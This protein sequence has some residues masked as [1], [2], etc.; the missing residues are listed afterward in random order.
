MEETILTVPQGGT[1]AGTFTGILKGNGHSPVTAIALTGDPTLFLNSQGVFANP[2]LVDGV[3]SFNGRVGIVTPQAGDYTTTIVAEG[4]N[5]YFTN[6]RSIAAVLTGYTS[7]AG[8]ISAAD[9]VL[10][11]IQKL[12]GNI[13]ALVTGVSS[14]TNSD[15]TLTITPNTGAVVASLALTHANI[16]TGKQTFNT[17]SPTFSTMTAGSVLFAGASG[18]LSQNN[19]NFYIQNSATTPQQLGTNTNVAF[20]INT[21]GD[22]T[23]TNAVNTYSQYD[24][25]LP[26][27]LITNSL[28]GL[29]TDGAI[30]GYTA[31]SSR[32]TGISPIQL[33]AGDLVGGYFGFGSQGASSPT[34]QN[35]GGMAIITTGV[36]TNN[37]GGELD[38]YTKADGGSLALNLSL[39][40]AGILTVGNP[41]VSTGSLTLA[42]ATSSGI[43]LQGKATGLS[44]VLTLPTGTGTVNALRVLTLSANSATP[45]I[46]TDIYS[47]V[48]IT[49][50]TAAITSF[51]TNLTGTPINDQKLHISITGT[52]SVAITFGTSFEPSG[53]VPLPTTT[54][55]TNRLDMVFIWNPE[56]SKWRCVSAA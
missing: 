52:A 26:N 22:D 28:T 47:D 48:E 17:T 49:A 46:N 4:S 31:S 43:T 8:V 19:T 32:G 24:A 53:L 20:S 38:W 50:Q 2:D 18:L 39:N 11:A 5:L 6:G 34:Y 56:T 51:T 36:S 40:N 14:V 12:N 10:S 55:S 16:W 33:N 9:S 42:G 54:N 21:N 45:A 35:L 27:S 15:G 37:L 13:T 44:S 30:P 7:G 29:N 3:I 25:Y 1:G 23:G 41:G